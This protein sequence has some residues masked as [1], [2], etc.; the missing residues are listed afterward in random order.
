MGK[1]G[2]AAAVAFAVGGLA[3]TGLTRVL[4]SFAESASLG[5]VGMSMMVSS[6]FLTSR[7]QSET[8]TGALSREVKANG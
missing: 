6:Y 8:G 3:M 1:A 4:G 7:P 5:L 2:V